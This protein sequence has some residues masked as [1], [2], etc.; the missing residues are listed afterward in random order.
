MSLRITAVTW[1]VVA[2]GSKKGSTPWVIRARKKK[3]TPATN[4]TKRALILQTLRPA[5]RPGRRAK[6]F[7]A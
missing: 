3:P 2:E 4:A 5:A 6:D 7:Q 1:L